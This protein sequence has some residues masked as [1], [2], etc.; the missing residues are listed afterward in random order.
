[1]TEPKGRLD[2]IRSV[3]QIEMPDTLSEL[4]GLLKN[5]LSKR[6]VQSMRL[7][8]GSPLEV[9]WYHIEGE[10]LLES[11]PSDP[12]VN[13]L[14]TVELEEFSSSTSSVK[15]LIYDAEFYLNQ[16]G[17]HGTYLLVGNI[18]SFKDSLGIP[19]MVALPRHNASNGSY[20]ISGTVLFEDSS[21][22]KDAVILL[23]SEVQ[24]PTPH[25]SKRGLRLVI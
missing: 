22:P 6:Y 23:G 24:N 12:I 7:S 11:M 15:E 18:Q 14:N 20:M 25:N 13:I 1:M 16:S 2:L 21:L 17:L 3:E 9:V 4:L 19:R 10:S 8:V 5:I